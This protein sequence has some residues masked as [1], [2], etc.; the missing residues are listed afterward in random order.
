M[1]YPQG[2][3]YGYPQGYPPAA[4]PAKDPSTGLILELIGFFGVCGIGWLWA[5]LAALMATR[6]VSLGIRFAGGRWVVLGAV[7]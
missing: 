2:G 3:N 6:A 4:P 1:Q 5:C 7:R